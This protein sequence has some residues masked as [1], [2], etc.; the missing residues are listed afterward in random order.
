MSNDSQNGP[1]NEETAI[2]KSKFANLRT[3]VEKSMPGIKAVLPK[4]VTPDRLA[5]VALSV[6]SR[7]P[8]LLGCTPQSL[9]SSIMVAGQLGLDLAPALGEAYLVPFKTACT[10]IIGYRGLVQLAR[11]S[12][13]ITRIE[14]HP[15]RLDDQF[16]VRFGLEPI[17]EHVPNIDRLEAFDKEA[18]VIG[19]GNFR[20]AYA[21]AKLKDGEPQFDVMTLTEILLIRSRS[22][23][24]RNA[25]KY[26][27]TDTPWIEHFDEMARKTAIRRLSKTLPLSI[28]FANALTLAHRAETGDPSLAGLEDIDLP[29][30]DVIDAEDIKKEAEGETKALP[31]STTVVVETRTDS[32]LEKVAAARKQRSDAGKPRG[33]S[34]IG[35]EPPWEAKTEEPAP[36]AAA[37]PAPAQAPVPAEAPAP[38]PEHPASAWVKLTDEESLYPDRRIDR[39][40]AEWVNTTLDAAGVS[41]EQWQDVY[42]DTTGRTGGSIRDLLNGELKKFF[43]VVTKIADERAARQS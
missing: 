12:G 31:E 16:R 23:G 15:V 33:R 7:T 8:K 13:Q 20:L 41:D 6:I 29:F 10:M 18:P 37:A 32:T 14:A 21:L 3:F 27:R 43:D 24:Y 26:N 19:E 40:R 25:V 22:E 11:R 30:G 39:E 9:V 42:T 36:P 4:H 1:T 35:E 17:L 2:A 38:A 5:K 34:K 28:E